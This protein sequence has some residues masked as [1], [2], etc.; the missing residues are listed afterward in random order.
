MFG[1]VD[2]LFE[3]GS[4]MTAP[5]RWPQKAE[6]ARMD[7]I[8]FARKIRALLSRALDEPNNTAKAVAAAI[9]YAAE[10]EITLRSV[11]AR[12]EKESE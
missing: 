2:G 1:D 3:D 9:N 11:G 10:I 6:D 5:L 4:R 8:A 12:A 7:S